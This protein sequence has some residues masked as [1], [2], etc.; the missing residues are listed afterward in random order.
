MQ[1]MTHCFLFL[2]AHCLH[3]REYTAKSSDLRVIL[4]CHNLNRTNEENRQTINVNEIK[5]NGDWDPFAPTFSGDV[6]YLRLA[7]SV[8]YDDY[9]RPICLPK[10]EVLDAKNGD[11]VGWG[12]VDDYNTI[13]D[14]PREVN[15]P[16][17]NNIECLQ[18]EPGL[19]QVAWKDSFCAGRS[20]VGV[21]RGDSGSG[22]YVEKDGKFYL[23]GIVSSATKKKCSQ[24]NLAIYTDIYKYLSF[25]N[26]VSRLSRALMKRNDHIF[27]L[28]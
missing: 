27:C 6:A 16:I 5:L 11:V 28:I 3:D 10:R 8:N 18:K 15:L 4:G 26:E 12:V 9:I 23:R 17:V 20:N 21:C 7:K 1:N 14:T 25:I 22:F 2:A 19:L 13:S 24:T